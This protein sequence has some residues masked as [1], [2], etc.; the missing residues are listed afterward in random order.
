MLRRGFTATVLSVP[1]HQS[2]EDCMYHALD[3]LRSQGLYLYD[4][5]QSFPILEQITMGRRCPT[6][7]SNPPSHYSCKDCRDADILRLRFSRLL[8]RVKV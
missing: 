5:D 1:H 8:S 6:E 7:A 2:T 3:V 4:L